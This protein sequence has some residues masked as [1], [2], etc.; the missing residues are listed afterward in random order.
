MFHYAELGRKVDKKDYEKRV[1]ELRASLLDLQQRLRQA[2]FPVIIVLSGDDRIGIAETLSILHEWMDPRSII[3]SVLDDPNDGENPEFWRFW[4]NLPPRGRIG[5]IFG[6]WYRKAIRRAVKNPDKKS[7]LEAALAR[8]NFFEKELADDGALILKFWLHLKK[9]DLEK[10]MRSLAKDPKAPKLSLEDE[11]KILRLY[12]HGR[13]VIERVLR[14]TSSAQ[15]PWRV[16][17][18][19][20]ARYR[21]LAVGEA[22]REELAAKLAAE[23]EPPA[24][25][26]S[27]VIHKRPPI[28][29]LGTLDLSKRLSR[30]AYEKQLESQQ[31][32]LNALSH[33]AAESKLPCIMVFE[34]WDAAGK[35][36]IIRRLT[37]PMDARHYRVIPIAAPTDE[38]LSY[39]YL[40]RFWRQIPRAGRLTVF[41]RSWYGRVLVERVEGFAR[42]AEWDRAYAEINDFE[43]QLVNHGFLLLKFWLQIDKAEQLRRFRERERT[44]YKQYKITPEDW[45]NRKKWGAYE[46]AVNDML[47]RTST[48]V[49][50]WTLV[51]ANDKLYARVKVLKTVCDA[52]AKRL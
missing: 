24:P 6:S 14:G 1:P 23:A 26:P 19:F 21:N 5:I 18:G 38:E 7:Q 34:G 39:P 37:M 27:P 41:D 4:V 42:P 48:D 29:V 2:K 3:T 17:E 22:L 36:G 20:D 35:G 52:L 10:R 12:D 50:P 28:D 32:R 46:A 25:K 33:E 11:R 47:V 40:W 15:A 44:P 30:S 16:V 8:I 9:S 45:R 51:E 43:D 13:R 49:A 31:R